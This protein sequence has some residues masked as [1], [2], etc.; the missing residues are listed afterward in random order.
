MIAPLAA[1]H[2]FTCARRPLFYTPI[3]MMFAHHQS[4]PERAVC[5]AAL[6]HSRFEDASDECL[7]R[8]F[9]ASGGVATAEEVSLLLRRHCE[10]PLSQLA[11]WIVGRSVIHFERNGQMLL[12]LFQFNV[13]D[14]SILPAVHSTL[15]H[16]D[17][18]LDANET[19]RWFVTPN[20]ALDGDQPVRR[21]ASDAESVIAAARAHQL[22]EAEWS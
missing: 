11:R 5:P 3:A 20:A 21:M 6:V 16:L 8:G 7:E 17:P 15:A 1:R 14:M 13:D 10:Q 18:S 4:Q 9:L 22:V 19:A 2:A 12:P